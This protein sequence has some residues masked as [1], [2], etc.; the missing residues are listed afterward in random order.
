VPGEEP[1]AQYQNWQAD[2]LYQWTSYLNDGDMEGPFTF[3]DTVDIDGI[4]TAA[5]D[6]EIGGDLDVAGSAETG[7][8]NVI[9][10]IDA[11]ADI[12]SASYVRGTSLQYS[13]ASILV[14]P[15]GAAA[16]RDAGLDTVDPEWIWVAPANYYV[17][18]LANA[19]LAIPVVL[20]VGSILGATVLYWYRAGATTTRGEWRRMDLSDGSMSDVSAGGADVSAGSGYLAS[21][22]VDP[23]HAVA[24]GYA[25]FFEVQGGDLSDRVFAVSVSLTKLS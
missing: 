22:L 4:L 13:T 23:A 9:G 12:V 10:T 8:L 18:N 6:V 7:N 17:R 20:P 1:A 5:D 16:V 19:T 25:Y 3:D 11:S 15:A 14:I 2:L 24:A 21:A